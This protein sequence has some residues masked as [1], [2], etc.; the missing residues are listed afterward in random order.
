MRSLVPSLITSYCLQGILGPAGQ[1]N[2]LEPF[3]RARKQGLEVGA[4]VYIMMEADVLPW[5]AHWGT[6]PC[7]AVDFMANISPDQLEELCRS[8]RSRLSEVE[9]SPVAATSFIPEISN[10]DAGDNIDAEDEKF[11]ESVWGKAICTLFRIAD[12]LQADQPRTVVQI[13]V[14]NVI[15]RFHVDDSQDA[16]RFTVS[17]R[18]R[19]A[20]TRVVLN[21]LSNCLKKI[22]VGFGIELDRLKVALEVEPGP[23][24]LLR[25]KESLDAFAKAI[26][27][28]R[29]EYVKKCIGFNLDIAHWCLCGDLKCNEELPDYIRERIFGAH[30]S[31]HSPR[32][33]FGDWGLWQ[34]ALRAQVN[35]IAKDQLDAYLGWL[36]LLANEDKTPNA[37]R[38]VS[39]E[40]E[41]AKPD[42]N[43]LASITT[44]ND[45]LS[46]L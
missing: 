29:C 16:P 28:H 27:G 4:D 3:I 13:V 5:C 21:R 14:G 46:K 11:V 41:A 43:V 15:D 10:I 22:Q 12:K 44:L 30:I 40:L 24:Y 20:L 8:I 37:S 32:G 33:H 9:T 18:D 38:Y 31:G 7:A 25:N 35:D 26:K 39:I 45:W 19:D 23:L 36:K 42:E 17:A 6:S 1:V 34:L 2:E